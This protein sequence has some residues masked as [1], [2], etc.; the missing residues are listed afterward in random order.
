MAALAALAFIVALAIQ[1]ERP[2]PGIAKFTPAG[3]LTTFNPEDA[4]DIRI[5]AKGETWRFH[6]ATSWDT[7]EGSRP[8]PAGAAARIDA[9]LR[10]LRNSRPLR[11]LTSEEI[12]RVPASE[13][14]L[15]PDNLRVEVR[16]SSGATFRIQ[17]GGR[18]PLGSARYVRVEGL[19]G[20][21]LLPTYVAEA[22]E[23]VVQ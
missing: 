9:A 13:Y 22:W 17:F 19:D 20:I 21:P 2:D 7:V 5:L 18:N 15:G 1:G 6:R 23:Q 10:L 11:V 12:S 4:R 16:A 8:V 14:A 3:L